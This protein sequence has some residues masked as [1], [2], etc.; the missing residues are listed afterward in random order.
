MAELKPC[1]FCGDKDLIDYE[2]QNYYSSPYCRLRVACRK[3]GAR[4]PLCDSKEQAIDAWNK[5][6]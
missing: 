4:G 2:Y 5:R 6:S 3:C 1:P